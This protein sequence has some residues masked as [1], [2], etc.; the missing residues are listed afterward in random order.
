MSSRRCCPVGVVQG[1]DLTIRA[2]SCI[3]EFPEAAGLPQA[4]GLGVANGR[5]RYAE[6]PGELGFR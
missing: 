4:S 2:E 5:D 6:D 1:Q 3:G